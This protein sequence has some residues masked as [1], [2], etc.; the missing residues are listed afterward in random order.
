MV[1]AVKSVRAKN[2]LEKERLDTQRCTLAA[3][4]R[5]RDEKERTR[6]TR[7]E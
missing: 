5:R 7:E 3:V 1:G 4:R 2:G 6:K